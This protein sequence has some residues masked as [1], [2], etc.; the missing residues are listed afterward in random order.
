M[1]L[2]RE[3]ITLEMVRECFDY[4]DGFLYWKV[5]QAKNVKKGSLAGHLKKY[6]DG[7]RVL[8]FYG[9]D[10]YASRMIFFWHNGYWPH[11][12]DHADRNPLNDRI[13]NLRE[14]TRSQNNC[15]KNSKPRSSS[16]YLGVSLHITTTKIFSEKFNEVRT[17]TRMGWRV[18]IK[19]IYIGYFK[20]QEEAALAYNKAAVK[21][22][23][24]FANLNIIKP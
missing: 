23:G 11:I 1:K 8:M 7:R 4:K 2:K 5:D 3:E 24:E 20:T 10:Y 18:K 6:S 22:H 17:Y 15:N 14:A 9:R 19:D 21:Y 13:E 16:K 12:V